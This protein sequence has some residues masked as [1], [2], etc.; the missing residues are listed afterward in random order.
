MLIPVMLCGAY[1]VHMHD[2]YILHV[3]GYDSAD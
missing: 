3:L 2:Q 1:V